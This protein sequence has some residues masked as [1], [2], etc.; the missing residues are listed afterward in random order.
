MAN[1]DD[2]TKEEF[3]ELIKPLEKIRKDI[4]V[5]AKQIGVDA[6][7]YYKGWPYIKLEWKNKNDLEC[8]IYLSMRDDNHSEFGMGVHA[9]LDIEKKRYNISRRFDEHIPTPFNIEFIISEI[10]RGFE[11]ANEWKFEDLKFSTV[12]K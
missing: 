9:W 7:Y 4:D 11:I 8:N 6:I 12:L 2:F 3:R 10:K 1:S 5:Y